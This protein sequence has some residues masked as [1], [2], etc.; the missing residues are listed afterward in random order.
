MKAPT[1]KGSA[2]L[3]VLGTTV[4]A[5]FA[6]LHSFR[7]NLA[8]RQEAKRQGDRLKAAIH[9]QSCAEYVFGLYDLAQGEAIP[10]TGQLKTPDQG[11]CTFQSGQDDEN[12]RPMTAITGTHQGQTAQLNLYVFLEKEEW[13]DEGGIIRTYRRETVVSQRK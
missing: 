8:A 13:D 11:E 4:I 2:W 12:G 3:I 6:A 7:L 9:A 1:R 5:L 10:K